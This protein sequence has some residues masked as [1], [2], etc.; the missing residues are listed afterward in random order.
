MLG[1]EQQLLPPAAV[2]VDPVAAVPADAV[3]EQSGGAGLLVVA[4]HVA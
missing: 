4:V 3:D 2:A 1:P